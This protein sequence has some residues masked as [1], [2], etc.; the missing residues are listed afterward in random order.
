MLV[1]YISGLGQRY[2]DSSQ[3]LWLDVVN[4]T[5]NSD[6][7]WFGPKEGTSSWENPWPIMGYEEFEDLDPPVYIRRAFEVATDYCSNFKF[8]I[9]QHTD[10]E[11]SW[12]KLKDLVSYLR[13]NGLRVDG[14]GWQAHVYMGWENIDGNKQRLYDFIDWCH[15]NDLE[16]HITEFNVWLKP[17]DELKYKEQAKTFYE[18][19]KLASSKAKTGVVG[20]NFWHIRGAETNQPTRDGGLWTEDY[21]PKKAYY[22]VKRAI[23]EIAGGVGPEIV[24]EPVMSAIVDSEYVY[25]PE[26]S[27]DVGKITYELDTDKTADW[28]SIDPSG[29]IRGTPGK[30]DTISITLT[31]TDEIGSRIQEYVLIVFDEPLTISSEPVTEATAVYPYIYELNG[32]GTGE[33]NLEST[34]PAEWLSIDANGIVSG[35]PSETG[36]YEITLS[37][38][39]HGETVFQEYILEVYE[40]LD[41]TSEP[42]TMATQG[43][44]Y[45]YFVQY[46]GSGEFSVET[47]TPA[48][49]LS[50]NQDG[51]LSGI[52]PLPDTIHVTITA[53]NSITTIIQEFDLHI[54]IES[55]SAIWRSKF[56]YHHYTGI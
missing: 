29:I 37:I 28:L 13:G 7:S 18:I 5:L 4:E 31:V 3:I 51:I 52:P 36:I 2:N 10:S 46:T 49:W 15:A 8:I 32:S 43:I 48:E 19:V 6:G 39:R 14:I 23:L 56:Y 12:S 45:R 20:I 34:P 54:V 50:I 55:D 38:T 35:T 25:E 16:F 9:N 33:Y 27:G 40:A 1:E 53:Q 24:T 47:D 30:T 21:V 17:E 22:D 41:I 44:L 11:E 26:V 42:K